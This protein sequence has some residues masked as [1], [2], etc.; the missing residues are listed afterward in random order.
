MSAKIDED[1]GGLVVTVRPPRRARRA[2]IWGLTFGGWTALTGYLSVEL[3]REYGQRPLAVAFGI[4]LLSAVVVPLGALF[5]YSFAGWERIRLSRDA[6]TLEH[7]LFRWGLRRTY[8]TKELSSFGHYPFERAAHQVGM[9]SGG[10]CFLHDGRLH[11]FGEGL[12][13]AEAARV[14]HAFHRRFE[15]S[16]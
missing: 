12:D 1:A 7:R 16:E 13:E 15:L 5:L 8:P 11:A 4:A 6:L 10:V 2:A 14:T 9:D 3:I